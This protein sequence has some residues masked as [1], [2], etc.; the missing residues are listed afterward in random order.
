MA[1]LKNLPPEKAL[2]THR[3]IWAALLMGQL[4]FAALVL[5]QTSHPAQPAPRIDP[6]L[7][8]ILPIVQLALA[9]TVIP[10]TFF[11]RMKTFRKFTVNGQLSPGGFG[12][13]NITFWAGCETVAFFGLVSILITRILWPFIALSALA[14]LFQLLTVPRKSQLAPPNSKFG[15]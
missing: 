7:L 2:M 11:L 8:T 3:V 12:S 13:G 14:F 9:L 6:Q 4:G 10:A 5:F 1:D 15:D